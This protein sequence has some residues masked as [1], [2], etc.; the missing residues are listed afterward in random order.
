MNRRKNRRV[1]W[2]IA[3]LASAMMVF[4]F[5]F[6]AV[7]GSKDTFTWASIGTVGT[8]D[9]AKAYDDASMETIWNVYETLIWYDGANSEKFIPV[10]ATKVPTVENG[11][12]TDGGKTIIFNIRK[13][14]KFHNGDILTPEDVEYSLERAMICDPD[15]G[16]MWML[17]EALVGTGSTRGSDG[18]LKPGIVDKIKK[19]VEVEG[20]NVVIRMPAPYPPIMSIFV[21]SLCSIIDKKWAIK[22]GCWD[23]NYAHAAK[24]NGPESG[25]EPLAK[26]ENGTGPYTIKEWVPSD[27]IVYERFDGY[28]GKKPPIKTGI[29][30]YVPEWSTRMLMM[31][32]GDLSVLRVPASHLPEVQ[33]MKNVR[34][35]ETPSLF[36][37]T[38]FFC[39]H[40]ETAGNPNIGSGKL[41]GNGIPPDFFSDIN[42]RKAFQHCFDAK[43]YKK[44]VTNGK[45]EIL[46]A[47]LPKG[48]PFQ[49]DVKGYEFNLKK[50][51]EYMKKAWGGK[52]WEKGFKMTILYNTGNDMRQAAANM[53]AENVMKLNPKFKIEVS[54]VE[55]KDYWVRYR[56]HIY[57]IFIIGWFADFADP[58][59][60]LYTF[61]SSNGAYGKHMMFRNEE[62]DRLCD[63]G[64]K[65]SRVSERKK[66]YEK[67]QE[68]W[69]K[70]ALGINVIQPVTIRAYPNN[71][72]TKPINSLLASIV[73]IKDHEIK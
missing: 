52:V 38:A 58:H 55:W 10:L 26:I 43:L 45:G 16:P 46:T 41:D 47:P 30:K 42:V 64:I 44:E 54:H 20:D 67:L 19:A 9:P 15:G 29:R 6:S 13:G 8:I 1:Q 39:Q 59:N 2:L 60:F 62:I 35:V 37:T 34:L 32:S 28:W 27:R 18:K 40:I 21:S 24:F 72:K 48:L 61:M 56:Q 49:K 53:I 69:V 23:G 50:A 3:L 22:N 14:V 57:P 71:V 70:Y 31:Q 7:A 51:A 11:G 73:L 33:E 12:I 4:A 17:L 63:A 65:E 25:K 66:I 68:L 36:V 5:T